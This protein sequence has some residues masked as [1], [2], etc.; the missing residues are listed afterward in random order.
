M[1][2]FYLLGFKNDLK[3]IV[4]KSGYIGTLHKHLQLKPIYLKRLI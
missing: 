2:I 4:I 1:R 3:L